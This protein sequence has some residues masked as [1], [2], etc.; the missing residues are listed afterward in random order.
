[1]TLGY[2]FYHR[3]M[4]TPTTTTTTTTLLTR[5]DGR[6]CLPSPSST[7]TIMIMISNS[8]ASLSDDSCSLENWG[9]RI[10]RAGKRRRARKEEKET[11]C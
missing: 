4:H 3:K 11:A 10:P 2:H 1:M 5:R 6:P 8:T 7:Y 9:A